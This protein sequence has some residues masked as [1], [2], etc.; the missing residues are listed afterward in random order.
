MA[1]IITDDAEWVRQSFLLPAGE[2]DTLDAIRRTYSEVSNS[3][4]DTT[5]GGNMVINPL[6]Q[7]TR[8]A[9]PKQRRSLGG[10]K[11]TGRYY[12][13]AY[14]MNNQVVNLRFGVPEFNSLTNFFTNFY[15]QDLG[16]LA[17]TGRTS[18]LAFNF[19]KIIGLAFGW[20]MHIVILVGHAVRFMLNK[21]IS[22]FY[23]LKP[24]MPLYWNTVNGIL[25][26]LATNMGL[27]APLV[28]SDYD[29]S[30]QAVFNNQAL[31]REEI[32]TM[33][34]L[35]P[36]IFRGD[37]G[38]D[39]YAVATR[40]QRL[41]AKWNEMILK[42]MESA[43]DSKDLK[44]RFEALSKADLKLERG[45]RLQEYLN[46]YWQN[47]DAAKINPETASEETNPDVPTGAAKEA[48]G[49]FERFGSWLS[50]GADFLMA[51]LRDGAQFVSLRVDHQGTASESFS[52]SVKEPDISG[53]FNGASST[54]RNSRYSLADGNV[55][56]DIILGTIEK[57]MGV[58]KDFALGVA[59]SVGIDGI[60]ALAGNAFAD[61]PKHWDSSSANLPR[62]DYTIQLRSWSGNDITRFQRLFIV[63]AMLLAGALPLATGN[64]S[65][66]SP[67][68]C[69]VYSRGAVQI[70][71]GIIDSL[72]I[73]RGVGTL[74]WN[75][76][77]KP[78]GI[79]ISFSVVDLS[80]LLYVP[81][82]PGFSPLDII[83]GASSFSA[84]LFA[85]DTPYHD[86]MAVLSS[87]SLSSQIYQIPKLVRNLTR[88]VADFNSWFSV[89]HTASWF[90][91]TIPGRIWSAFLKGTERI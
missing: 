3:F 68:L 18:G 79:D 88:G 55:G 76:D 43:T 7:F 2:L 50:N 28:Q 74:G 90:A 35:L 51:E 54:A 23:Y 83:D 52:N 1:Y 5:L 15:D 82:A 9:D 85:E 66:R 91:G 32:A 27:I 73:T 89:S 30:K 31:S 41:S 87:M 78:L 16:R 67:F 53:V 33:N 57:V 48:F 44:G 49:T 36:D 63:P 59:K 81:I 10:S 72:T 42:A 60:A 69:E 38:I 45:R 64:S 80:S 21:P 86:Y 11:G 47:V 71:L 4:T 8:Y 40:A 22:R 70:R 84:K 58:V 24:A 56:D 61:F 26:E 12:Y 75:K 29:E 62:A 6:P 25:N 39:I 46:D 34:R 20:P 65:Y 77:R 17:G 19:G 13:E 14:D 37:G